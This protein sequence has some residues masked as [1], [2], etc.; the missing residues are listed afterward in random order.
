MPNM[1]NIAQIYIIINICNIKKEVYKM[2]HRRKDGLIV[3]R[4]KLSNGKTKDVYAH[5]TA[6]LNEKIKSI[7]HD[8]DHG[9]VIGNGKTVDEWASEWIKNYL[10]SLAPTTQ[11]TYVNTYNKHI[12]P[13]LAAMPL[14][15]VRHVNIQSVMN[16]VSDKSEALQ[17]NILATMRRLFNTAM[18]N[19][20]IEF[21]PCDGIKITPRRDESSQEDDYRSLDD[22]QRELLVKAVRGTRAELFVNIGLW[23]GLRREET[24]GLKWDDV[25]WDNS[26]LYVRRTVTFPDNNPVESEKMKS[27]SSK[28]EVPIPPPL[29]DLLKRANPEHK[30]AVTLVLH[31]KYEPQKEVV[32]VSHIVS[33][34]HGCTMSKSSFR[35]MW[36]KVQSLVPFEVGTHMLRHTYCTWLYDNGIDLKTAKDL[37]GH[38][39]IRITDKI[40]THIGEKQRKNA[41]QKIQSIF[42]KSVEKKENQ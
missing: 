33:N 1:G 11:A 4:I 23:C 15:S 36:D 39:D 27:K 19:R 30:G 38:S 40:Y 9:I 41:R 35:K 14:K 37:M 24:L 42:K 13:V 32:L 22:N 26:V 5:S 21:N 34:T 16:N 20:L 31:H 2:Q 28:R 17:H 3:K 10:P 8:A 7:Q 6:E 12:M 18:Q 29:M 25:D